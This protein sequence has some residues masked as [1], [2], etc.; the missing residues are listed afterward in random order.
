MNQL[1]DYLN[2]VG[3]T[4]TAIP[5]KIYKLKDSELVKILEIIDAIIKEHN[6][7]EVDSRFSFVANNTLSGGSQP[8][9]YIDCR[10]KNID[11]LARNAILYADVVYITNPF[12]KYYHLETFDES[13]RHELETDFLLVYHVKALL[14]CGI[15]KFSSSFIHLC[16]SCLRKAKILTKPYELKLEKAKSFLSEKILSDFK[17]L[18]DYDEDDVPFLEVR[19]TSDIA[20]HPI[21]YNF[22][23]EVLEKFEALVKNKKTNKLTKKDVIEMGFSDDFSSP[24]INDLMIQNYY[25]NTFNS[26][27]LTNRKIDSLL[28]ANN[29][30][31]S[32][33][34]FSDKVSQSLNHKVPFLP[35]SSLNDLIKLRSSEGEA[36]Q[37]YRSSL[38]KFLSS[39][40]SKDYNLK[41]AFRDEI[42]P[43]LIKINQTIKKTRKSILND[44]VKDTLVGSTFV[45]I[46]LFTN[47]LPQAAGAIVTGVGGINYLDKFGNNIKKLST[48]KSEVRENKY[49]FIWKLLRQ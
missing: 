43:E 39:I 49:Y 23:G 28:I 1:F 30:N 12:E 46:G 4:K 31:K 17:F 18:I 47:F 40:T 37:L 36:F 20:E 42:E 10:I 2:I 3:L 25:A 11:T 9:T 5:K 48:I 24:I 45:S 22:S 16:K 33:I 14:V 27:Y 29:Q 34:S 32:K 44:L 38:T 26:H 41:E 21:I 19:P 15:F 35:T 7:D 13:D 8:C 6:M